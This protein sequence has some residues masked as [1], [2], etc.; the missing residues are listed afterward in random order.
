MIQN[1][2]TLNLGGKDRTFHLG[3]GFIGYLLDEEN[4]GFIEFGEKEQLNPFKWTPIKMYY[5]LKYNLVFS[6]RESEIDF[7]LKD[8]IQWIDDTDMQ[9]LQRFN[10][11]YQLALSKDVPVDTSKKKAKVLK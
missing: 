10:Q 2:V 6:E 9:T 5:S 7:N 4:I 11:A 8:V 1:K 3:L